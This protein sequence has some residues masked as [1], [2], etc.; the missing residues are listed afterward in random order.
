MFLALSKSPMLVIVTGGM[1]PGPLAVPC[2]VHAGLMLT[3]L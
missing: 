1:L 2:G 3:A